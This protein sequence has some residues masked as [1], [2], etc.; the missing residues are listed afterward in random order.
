MDSL[1]D[2]RLSSPYWALRATYVLVPLLAGLDKFLN[3]LTY[4]PHYLSPAAARIIPMSAP[5]FMRVVGVIEIIAGLLVLSK[6]AR[7]GAYIVMA[8]LICIALN[9]VSIRMYDV[10]VRDAA[11][12]VGAYALA[13]LEEV[14]V[15]SVARV[16][17]VTTVHA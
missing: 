7:V 13:R 14:R 6:F 15:G 11:M 5:A 17:R 16:R 4:W 1:S 3:L 10:A 9:L 12:A 2:S 8:W